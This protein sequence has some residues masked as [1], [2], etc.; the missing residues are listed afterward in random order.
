MA[1]VQSDSRS[2]GWTRPWPVR[3]SPSRRLSLY[4]FAYDDGHWTPISATTA[5]TKNKAYAGNGNPDDGKLCRWNLRTSQLA[6]VLD[7]RADR[8]GIRRCTMT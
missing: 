2:G 4:S 8:S 6:V 3:C 5:M 1:H 7:A